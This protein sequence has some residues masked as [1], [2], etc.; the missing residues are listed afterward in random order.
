V[1]NAHGRIFA[2]R[3]E[4][5]RPSSDYTLTCPQSKSYTNFRSLTRFFKLTIPLRC[6]R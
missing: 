4:G 2:R 5:S 6:L 3:H 1:R